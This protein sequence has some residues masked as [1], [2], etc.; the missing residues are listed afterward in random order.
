[1]K[2]T[3]I[4]VLSSGNLLKWE[5]ETVGRRGGF[6]AE[7]TSP[8]SDRD[9][10]EGKAF[11]ESFVPQRATVKSAELTDQATAKNHMANHLFGGSRN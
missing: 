11:V 9:M 8:P 7:F 10:R 2:K 1:M 4:E 5:H 3:G 6:R